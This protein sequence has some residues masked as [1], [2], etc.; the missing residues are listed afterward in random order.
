M[1]NSI[2]EIKRAEG[3]QDEVMEIEREKEGQ[4]KVR[5]ICINKEYGEVRKTWMN[6]ECGEVRVVSE[7]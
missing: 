4:G 3:R 6:E 5:K 7:A 1:I 2:I